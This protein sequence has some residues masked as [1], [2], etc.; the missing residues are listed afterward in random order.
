M[1]HLTW[2]KIPNKVMRK[3]LEGTLTEGDGSVQLTSLC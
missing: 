1:T 3:F 2:V